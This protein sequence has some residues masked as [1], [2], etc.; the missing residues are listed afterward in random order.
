MVKRGYQK[1]KLLPL[2]MPKIENLNNTNDANNVHCVYI[3][4]MIAHLRT[5]FT[6]LPSTY[7]ELIIRFLRSIPQGHRQVHIIAD[8]YR[9]GSIKSGEREKCGSAAKVIIVLVKSKL[10]RDMNQFLL[11]NENKTVY[12]IDFYLCKN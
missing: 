4:D 12:P 3:V 7:E 1:G 8:T 5:C 9:D 6:N 10:P 2:L 11:N